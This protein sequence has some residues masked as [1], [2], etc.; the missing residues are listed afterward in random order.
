MGIDVPARMSVHILLLFDVHPVGHFMNGYIHARYANAPVT[1]FHEI[2]AEVPPATQDAVKLV[3]A[4]AAVVEVVFAFCEES[5]FA[6]AH[7]MDA[8][9]CGPTAPYPVVLGEPEETRLWLACQ[10]CT[11]VCV[12][13]PNV[14]VTVTPRKFWSAVTCPFVVAS[15]APA[16][17]L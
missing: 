10:A 16:E 14:P 3:G 1:G 13:V 5:I 6:P 2:E 4:A 9:V 11:A 8:R 7:A 17:K 12:C 15:V